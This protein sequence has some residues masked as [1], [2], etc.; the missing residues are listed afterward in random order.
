MMR[1]LS[2]SESFDFAQETSVFLLVAGAYPFFR[3]ERRPKAG[4]S[5]KD[6]WA[7]S[8]GLLPSHHERASSWMSETVSPSSIKLVTSMAGTRSLQVGGTGSGEPASA[9]GLGRRGVCTGTP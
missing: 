8:F 6:G 3:S 4:V 9:S 7:K 2:L 1:N 5:R